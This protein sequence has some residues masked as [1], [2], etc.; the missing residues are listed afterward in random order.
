VIARES[1]LDTL[2]CA[3]AARGERVSRAVRD[4]VSAEGGAGTATV[5]GSGL[6][7]SPARAALANGT[8]GHAL[9]YDDVNWAMNGHPSVPLLP[10][11]LAVAE[12][13]G[14]S[15]RQLLTAYVAGFE[16]QARVGQALSLSHYARGWH[17]T[18]TLGALGATVAV[19]KL[20]RLDEAAL[21]RAIGIA[22]AQLAGSR[23]SFGTDAKPL[24]AGLAAQA[25][26][27]AASLAAR[28]VTAR[29]DALEAE[30]GVGDL[31]DG[32]RPLELPPLGTP[33]ALVDPGVELKPYPACRF[34]HR[35]IDGMLALRA[36]HPRAELDSIECAIDPFA[37]KILI[38]P[39]P[40]TGLEA[41]FSLP[42]CAAVTWLDGWPGL[43]AFSDRRAAR[44]DVQQLLRRVEVSD[45]SGPEDEVRIVL[46]SGFRASERVRVAR[47]S[48]EKP[49]TQEE[50]LNKARACA[51]PALGEPRTEEL[52]RRVEDLERLTDVGALCA[53]LAVEEVS[54]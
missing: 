41:K 45:A 24:H 15:G 33:F 54:V 32:S 30:M 40:H 13:L 43:E 16:A 52:I 18:A 34:T 19:G 26:V 31:Y 47:G 36:R 1:I 11:A 3:L 48:P 51:A 44:D 28:G 10:A 6:R 21:R 49:M 29:E 25:G 42:Y 14:A 27:T 22:A 46:R 20:L 7:T 39:R 53:L 17:P 9:D 37:Q 50:R 35:T 8:A 5:W 2:A 23:M 12:A 4:W 38:H